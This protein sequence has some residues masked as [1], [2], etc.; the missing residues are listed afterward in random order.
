MIV[1]FVFSLVLVGL[2]IVDIIVVLL[3]RK[4]TVYHVQTRSIEPPAMNNPS[5]DSD[6][7][8]H[9]GVQQ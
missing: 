7:D 5:Q 9:E 4:S 8:D 1:A 2:S 3:H 6:D